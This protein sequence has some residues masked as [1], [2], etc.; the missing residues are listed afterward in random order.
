L[1]LTTTLPVEAPAN[2]H[3][4]LCPLQACPATR[5]AR[6]VGAI[7]RDDTATGLAWHTTS[8]HRPGDTGRENSPYAAA[9]RVLT[10]HAVAEHDA[11][12]EDAQILLAIAHAA[13]D[14]ARAAQGL[15]P[16]AHAAI[17][18][19]CCVHCST[20]L[21]WTESRDEWRDDLGGTVC[22]TNARLCENLCRPHHR[23]GADPACGTCHGTGEV[24]G[25]HEPIPTLAG[26]R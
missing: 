7:W 1:S 26:A 22:Q 23:D 21:A 3:K 25:L 6:P 4:I 12:R 18:V 15:P 24:Y 20:A 16:L 2:T 9:R 14:T 8:T 11:D 17:T 5:A 19:G 13:Q 10:V